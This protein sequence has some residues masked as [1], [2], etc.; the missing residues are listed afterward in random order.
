MPHVLPDPPLLLMLQLVTAAGMRFTLACTSYCIPSIRCQARFSASFVN[1]SFSRVS[2][3]G[4]SSINFIVRFFEDCVA[5]P[6]AAIFF[7]SFSV[8]SFRCAKCLKTVLM[9]CDDIGR[10][11]STTYLTLKLIFTR[12]KIAFSDKVYQ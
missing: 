3:S 11:V 2:L 8:S 7:T 10:N 6:V 12:G 9:S 5:R 4:L 1:A